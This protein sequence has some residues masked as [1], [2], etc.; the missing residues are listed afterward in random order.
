MPN[1]LSLPGSPLTI[2]SLFSGI[3]GLWTLPDYVE[4]QVDE[5]LGLAAAETRK[6]RG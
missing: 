3:G 2:G 1:R 6:V 5:Q 4:R